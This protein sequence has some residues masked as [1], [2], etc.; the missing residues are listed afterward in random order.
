MNQS[1]RRVFLISEL[2]R[3]AINSREISSSTK[4]P[5]KEDKQKKFLR[6]LLNVRPP[7]A[8]SSEFIKIQDEYFQEELNSLD[9]TEVSQLNPVADKI[10]L[11]Q[12]DISKIRCGAIVNAANSDMLGCFIPC[13]NCVDNAIH[14]AAGL[15]LRAECAEIM[16]RLGRSLQAGEARLTK[17]YNLPCQ[18]VIH[19]VGPIIY[20]QLQKTDEEALAACYRNS[21]Q[22]AHEKGLDSIAFC[23]ISTGVY[24][25]PN[26][27][28]A[29]IALRTTR[30]YLNRESTAPKVIFTVLL[31]KDYAI[32][33]EILSKS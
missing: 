15:Q 25:F 14:S 10:Y 9:I 5:D 1:E 11:H 23:C 12:G 33:K 28:A 8:I 31:D 26:H 32:Y 22:L 17:A 2:L 21:L 4:I 19:T 18:Y 16:Q 20:R 7:K 27:R 24:C 29:E 13:H 3:E 30:D 6:S